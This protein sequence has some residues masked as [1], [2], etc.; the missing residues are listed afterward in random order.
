MLLRRLFIPSLL[1]STIFTLH[2]S[3]DPERD[4]GDDD[5]GEGGDGSAG[6]AGTSSSGKGGSGKGGTTGNAGSSGSAT[7][8]SSAGTSPGI[9]EPGETRSCT[10]P[11]GCEGGQEC[12][13][14]GTWLACDCG[15][16]SGGMSSGGTGSS[17]GGE[18]GE[19]DAV[20]GAGGM[21]GSEDGGTSGTAGSGGSGATAGSGGSG[22]AG[23]GGTGGASGSSGSSGAGGSSAGAGGGGGSSGASGG[24]SGSGGS[25]GSSGSSGSGGS[26]GSCGVGQGLELVPA[27]GDDAGTGW[28]DR[29]TNCVGVQGA[30]YSWHDQGGSEITIS[31]ADGR[32][33]VEGFAAEILDEDFETYWGSV[34]SIHLN[35]PG[36]GGSPAAYNASTYG[37]DGFEFTLTGSD[38]PA[39]LRP[40]VT[41]ANSTEYCKQVCASGDQSLLF[42]EAHPE[43]WS[44]EFS[45]TPGLTQL[46]TLEFHVPSVRGDD[47]TFDFC[48]EDITAILDDTPVGDPGECS[49]GG[50]GS[51]SCAG[52]CDDM[53]PSG[54]FCDS[55]CSYIGDCCSDYVD[56]CG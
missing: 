20:G 11:G 28:I 45:S 29:S 24:P 54:C 40:R 55:D 53:A 21:G 49:S 18:G 42:S 43:C 37:I 22:N 4:R 5:A 47:V 8:G 2:C 12:S 3:D 39:E 10:G 32:I 34:V 31:D 7:G 44:D 48:I 36:G 27:P 38:I 35:H 52:Y 14:S 9:C 16:G 33:C 19:D 6:T 23:S 26:A 41:V 13:S 15:S 30:V 25:S 46:M 17:E 50:S 1:V 51:D 56:E